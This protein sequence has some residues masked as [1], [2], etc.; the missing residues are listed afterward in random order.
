[1]LGRFRV[2][3]FDSV[4][5]MNVSRFCLLE[6]SSQEFSLLL[7]SSSFVPALPSLSIMA[8]SQ[9][10]STSSDT[11]QR[12]KSYTDVRFPSVCCEYVLLPFINKET[13]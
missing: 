4:T 9:Y 11:G 1:M 6:W 10:I 3:T 7:G 13:V 12:E 2:L 5:S 8:T